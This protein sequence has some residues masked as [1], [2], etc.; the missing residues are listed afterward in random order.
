MIWIWLG[1]IIILTLLELLTNNMVTIFFAVSAIISLILSIFID[2]F[3]IEFLIFIILGTIL[4]IIAR[5]YLLKLINERKKLN[6]G[7]NEK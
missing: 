2:N 4:L 3:F 1:I 5:D 6:R 7:K